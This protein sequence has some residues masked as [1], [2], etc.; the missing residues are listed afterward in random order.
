MSKQSIATQA[1]RAIKGCDKGSLLHIV[2]SYM[3]EYAAMSHETRETELSERTATV[4]T[5]TAQLQDAREAR[6]VADNA[7]R[8]ARELIGAIRES[9]SYR[10]DQKDITAKQACALLGMLKADGTPNVNAWGVMRKRLKDAAAQAPVEKAERA[11]KRAEDSAKREA[12][13]VAKLSYVAMADRL[14]LA[15]HGEWDEDL[16]TAIASLASALADIH[17]RN[18]VAA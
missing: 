4:E 7:V 11:A 3:D 13:A 5:L 1:R 17:N 6:K 2:G 14:I 15:M 8:E 10:Q 18:M 16:T 9:V 12:D